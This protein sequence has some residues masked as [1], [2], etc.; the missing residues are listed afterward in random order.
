MNFYFQQYI[1]SEK[2]FQDAFGGMRGINHVTNRGK[3][4]V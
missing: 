3:A 2:D 1:T 4:G